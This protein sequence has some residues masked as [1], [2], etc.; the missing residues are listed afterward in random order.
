MNASNETYYRRMQEKKLAVILLN[1][2]DAIIYCSP[3]TTAY[4]AVTNA[5]QQPTTSILEVLDPALRLEFSAA[6]ARARQMH[7][8]TQMRPVPYGAAALR[9]MVQAH[10]EPFEA[11]EMTA[12][13]MLVTFIGEP[14]QE[15]PTSSVEDTASQRVIADL[16]AELM[17]SRDEYHRL[18]VKHEDSGKNLATLNEVLYTISDELRCASQEFELN[19]GTLEAGN[20]ILQAMVERVTKARTDL[21]NIVDSSEPALVLVD[22]QLRIVRY[23]LPAASLFS[24]TQTDIGR[25]L[26]AIS[27]SLDYPNMGTDIRQ[28][29][30]TGERVEGEIRSHKGNWFGVRVAPSQ[31][32]NGGPDGVSLT[33]FDISLRKHAEDKLHLV[34]SAGNWQLKRPGTGYGTGMSLQTKCFCHPHGARLSGLNA[35][36]FQAAHRKSGNP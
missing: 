21:E 20:G 8:A 22:A 30:A 33:F 18:A 11:D 5:G 34:N 16:Y 9:R 17:R 35:T 24:V 31:G 2:R 4:L 13:T 25:T 23:T 10:I 7:G 14:C 3:A 28:V 29:L 36:N 27:H 19:R 32:A 6:L 12:G 26:L 1:E 15:L